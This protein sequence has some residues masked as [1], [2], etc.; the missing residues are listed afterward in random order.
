M[1]YNCDGANLNLQTTI[2][3][4]FKNAVL[5]S[6][7]LFVV[8]TALTMRFEAMSD[9]YTTLGF[10]ITFLQYTEGKC[11]ACAQFFKWYALTVDLFIALAF[12]FGCLKAWTLV[13]AQSK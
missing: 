1:H 8:A 6:I 9:G 5:L 11:V 4:M 2:Y 7:L 10:P 3:L 13:A 12:A